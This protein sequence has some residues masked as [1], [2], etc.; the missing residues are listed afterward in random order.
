MGTRTTTS[1]REPHAISHSLTLQSVQ[2]GTFF[3][4]GA[5][6]ALINSPNPG[7]VEEGASRAETQ[8]IGSL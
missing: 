2:K 6:T 7:L 3:P 5:G 1:P 8:P 4:K